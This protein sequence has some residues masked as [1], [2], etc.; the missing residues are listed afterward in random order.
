MTRRTLLLALLGKPPSRLVPIGPAFAQTQVNATIFS[1]PLAS[2]RKY[3]FAAFYSPDSRLTLARREFASTNWTANA[4]PFSGNTRDAHNGI[5]LA[6]DGGGFLHVAWD[7]HV[8]PL[9]Y[10]VSRQPGSL[11]LGPK[12]SMDGIL[13]DSVTYPEFFPLDNGDLLFLYRHGASGRGDT[14]LKRFSAANRAW[15]TLQSKLIDGQG[16]RNAYTNRIAIDSSGRWHLSWCW[17]E[18]GDVA[19]NHDICYARSDDEGRTWRRSN[20][21]P[22]V[23]PI[24]VHT[25]EIAATIPQ[26]SDLINQ[27]TMAAGG[28][29]L[30]AIA[31]YWRQ[32]GD[33]APQYRVVFH[34]GNRWRIVQA[35]RRTVSF[36]LKGLGTRSIPISRPLLLRGSGNSAHLVFRD[37]GRLNVA[38][39]LTCPDLFALRP[40]WAE[41][42]LHTEPLDR[43][44]PSHDAMQWR[45]FGRLHLFHLRTG[46]ADAETPTDTPPQLASV[47]EV[48]L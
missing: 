28:D 30:P 36:T 9:R 21:E 11:D 35:G 8:H 6:V 3:Q 20:G 4:T 14:I 15:S 23:L 38:S 18:S 47:L 19:T 16:E 44:E 7:H 32:P 27:T 12:Q 13:E 24:T 17:R 26:F 41:S 46:Q 25:A 22:Y 29:G 42:T 43:W 10:S 39:L 2:D 48:T 5:A 1:H 40:V 34:D 37:E 33:R 31:S 45:R